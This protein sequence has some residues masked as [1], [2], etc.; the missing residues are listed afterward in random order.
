MA[1]RRR[2]PKQ[3]QAIINDFQA[4]GLSGVE[5]CHREGIN[6]KSFYRAKS[7]YSSRPSFKSFIQ[8]T[9]QAAVS[10]EVVLVLP[11]CKIQCSSHVSP[12]WIAQLVNTLYSGGSGTP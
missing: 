2:T 4:S 7:A 10:V 1:S 5:F 9:P 8:A 3:W 12:Q 11:N 6:T